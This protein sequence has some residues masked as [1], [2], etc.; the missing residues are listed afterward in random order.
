MSENTLSD[1]LDTIAAIATAPGDAG[2]AV[3]RVS[4]PDALAIGDSV[5]TCAGRP[6]SGRP[7]GAF[8]Y[9]TVSQSA[10]GETASRHVD[11]AIVLV[12]RSPRSYTREDVVEFQCHGGRT[13][14]ARVLRVVL[15]SGARLA[16]PGEFTR[17]AFLNGRIDLLQAEAVA[18]LI[19][20]RSDRA[21][22]AALDQL[23]GSLST[24]FTDC[25]AGLISI[26]ADLEATL[27]FAEDELPEEVLDGVLERTESCLAQVAAILGGFEEGHLLREG[28]DAVISGQPNVGKSTLMNC[29]LGKDRAIVTDVPGTTRDVIEEQLVL[30]GIPIRLV[31]TAGLR[32]SACDIEREGVRRAHDRI[33]RADVNIHVMD[34]SRPVDDAEKTR[35]ASLKPGRALVVLNKTDL[36]ERV[37]S[38]LLPPGVPVV[39]CALLRGKGYSEV[40]AGLSALIHSP[41]VGTGI[42]HAV[43]SERHR[44][45][46]QEVRE[47]VSEVRDLLGSDRDESVVL[48]ATLLREA[49]ESLGT[50]TGR[51]YSDELLDAV[52]SRFCIGK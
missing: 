3:V 45:I 44:A 1:T 20:A 9:G 25:Y 27:D 8:I 7:G 50:A 6:P 24:A 42:P 5:F 32:D 33:E 41:G 12:Y 34:A 10:A 39:A 52:F 16:D 2:I 30:D 28:I 40:Q 31:D 15:Q 37:S 26:A 17:R 47:R 4:G 29:L 49:I 48:A 13:S 23:E 36:G 11:E 22:A 21:A 51:V 35:L 14:A 19:R 38:E 43:I 18:D 46:L